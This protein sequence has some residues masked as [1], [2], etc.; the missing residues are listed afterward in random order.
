M[1]KLRY[2]LG[3]LIL[4][5]TGTGV[6]WLTSILRDLDDRPGLPLQVEFRDA[7]GLR[8]GADVRHRGVTVGKVRSVAL[9]GDGERAVVRVLLDPSVAPLVCL[10]SSFWV[11]TPRFGGLTGSTTGLE[12]LV[13]D[14]YLAF[15]TPVERGTLLP[16]DGLVVGRELPPLDLE[17]EALE[18]VSHGDLLMTMLVP[19]NHGLRP[20]SGV[21]FRGVRTGEVRSIGLSADGS[22][23]EVVLRIGRKHRQTVTDKSAFWIARPELSGA[24]LSGFSITDLN[25][26]L[27]PFVG[28]FGDTGKGLPVQDGHRVVAVVGRPAVD[29]GSVMPTALRSPVESP[30]KGLPPDAGLSVVRVVYSAV[31]RR[32]LGSDR[33]IDRSGSGLLFV[34]RNGRCVVAV[35]RSVVDGTFAKA[36]WFGGLP[37]VGEERINIL[38]ANGSVLR[39]TRAWI[40]PQ[41]ADMAA[42]LVEAAPQS[43]SGT[44]VGMLLFAG[45]AEY[46]SAELRWAGPDGLPVPGG[47]MSNAPSGID[48]LGASV[49][50]DGKVVGLL[51]RSGPGDA[52]LSMMSLQ[53]LPSDLRP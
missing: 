43:L 10:N 25:A 6:I 12:T 29:V 44:S 30:T 7:R 27:A 37:K 11:V 47:P 4:V 16:A 28:Y 8:A 35:P 22:H 9:A 46:A 39:A 17:P 38:L 52:E 21:V 26:L 24:L 1:N 36:G 49:L 13:R 45:D 2:L 42:I 34:D 33:S 41:G 32:T 23:V 3:L 53:L 31:E 50:I 48:K 14:A 15:H 19:E 18:E 20:G 51:G 5:A 40:D